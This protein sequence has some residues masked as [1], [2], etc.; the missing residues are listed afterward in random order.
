MLR[1]IIHSKIHMASV[2]A[3]LPE[4]SGSIT[5]DSEL[6]DACGLRTN[7]AVTVA[8]CRT[9]ARFETYVFR[10]PKGSRRIEVN[11][12]AA[13]LVEIGDRIIILHYAYVDD[14][15]YREFHPRVV[16]VHADNAIERVVTYTPDQRPE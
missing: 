7:D 6:L 12:A 13:R 11:G 16:L 1:K 9:G 4:Y 5:I 10:A 2:T 15:E 14:R 3:A 8:N